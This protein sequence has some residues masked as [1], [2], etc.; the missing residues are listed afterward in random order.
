MNQEH[1]LEAEA[2]AFDQ[3]I[4]ERK[5]AGYIPDI[6]RAVKCDYFYKSFWRDPHFVKLYL[7]EIAKNIL[8]MIQKNKGK[9][10]KILDAGCGA[11]YF[12]LELAR[13][14]Y[15]VFGID[16][17]LE[18]I[19][20]AKE[21]LAANPFKD[22][23]GSLKYKVMSFLDAEGQYDVILFSGVLHHFDDPEQAICKAIELLSPKGLVICYEPCHESWRKK[24]AAH[25]ALIRKLLSLTGLWYESG[26]IK[27]N[28]KSYTEEIHLEYIT[29]K[30]KNERGQSPKDNS[31]TGEEILSCLRKQLDELEYKPS[32]SFIYRL[33]GGL[34]G[35]GLVV[36]KIADILTLYDR[37]GVNR[38]FLKP[39][40]FYFVGRKKN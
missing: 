30:D 27:K 3:R 15:Q 36:R 26:L 6:R 17:S 10:L 37:F 11:G 13:E 8:Q 40:Y 19:E 31:A 23:F 29:E 34:R 33:L 1:N 22:G 9:N 7:G 20:A 5:N 14:G 39:N 12:S 21:T 16:I 38:G 18:S 2:V 32:F 24:D 28:F 35:P 25:V 4:K